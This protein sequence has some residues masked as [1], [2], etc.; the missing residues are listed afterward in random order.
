MTDTEKEVE[1]N[2]EDAVNSEVTK[3]SEE[4]KNEASG[5]EVKG[6][7]DNDSDEN[8][9]LEMDNDES[10]TS[11]DEKAADVKTSED[12]SAPAKSNKKSSVEEPIPIE[13][14][15]ATQ[16]QAQYRGQKA[17]EEVE[18]HRFR[19][20]K[21][22]ERHAAMLRRRKEEEEKEQKEIDA[23][24]SK[25]AVFEK[26]EKLTVEMTNLTLPF[27]PIKFKRKQ[28]PEDNHHSNGAT[29]K[30]AVGEVAKKLYLLNKLQ[31]RYKALDMDSDSSFVAETPPPSSSLEIDTDLGP[32]KPPMIKSFR[33]LYSEDAESSA[34]LNEADLS[35]GAPSA[36]HS[37][38]LNRLA[39]N[40]A[41]MGHTSY[42]SEAPEM[43]YSPTI[44]QN[45]LSMSVP[46]QNLAG[47]MPLNGPPPIHQLYVQQAPFT[48]YPPP[49]QSNQPMA[50]YGPPPNMSIF[51]Q[52]PQQE[53][54]L[55]IRV[56]TL[57]FNA[58]DR[59]KGLF[60]SMDNARNGMTSY[61]DF[62]EGLRLLR[63]KLSPQEISSIQRVFDP[64]GTGSLNYLELCESLDIFGRNSTQDGDTG[65]TGGPSAFS[66]N[67]RQRQQR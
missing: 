37:T 66:S 31:K 11:T 13:T 45:P 42:L 27:S 24:I 26:I 4:L 61:S 54:E 36:T 50:A 51:M 9:R 60:Q 14:S 40:G 21:R 19:L 32:P 56:S 53:Q 23:L 55:S 59:I 3:E 30:Q 10:Q 57:L 17:R 7:K 52:P 47:G 43:M 12:D 58:L 22:K 39:P 5:S 25:S 38:P 16:I 15:A 63:I 2:T 64:Q 41:M 67:G 65:G 28:V 8:K 34:F 46:T 18:L 33:N 62:T 29:A 49:N 48:Y 20:Q 44:P 35:F 1:K 6:D